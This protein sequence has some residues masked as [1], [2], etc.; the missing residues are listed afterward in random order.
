MTVPKHTEEL[1]ED[2]AASLQVPPGRYE[3]AERSYKSVAEW[4]H[5]AA[6]RVRQANP[7]VYVQGSFRL[8]TAIRPMSDTEDYDVDL[9]C[10]LSLPKAKL[11]QA[12]LKA[13]L[14]D[15]LRSYADAHGMTEPEEGRRCWTQEYADGAQFHMDTLP[16]LPDAAGQRRILAESGFSD[17][18]ADT[19]IA[20]T[21]RDDPNFRQLTEHWPHSNPK[22]YANWFRSR[23]R[24]V[25]D[26]RH[27]ALALEARASVEDIPEH[28]VRTPLQ[29]AIQIL[30]HH[31]DVM[32][33]GR[34][35]DKP[36]SIILTTLAAHAYQQEPIISGALYSILD[37]MDA[38]IDYSTGVA[39]IA[40]PTDP[41]EN[42][43]DRW[44]AYPRREEAFREWLDRVRGDFAAAAQS[45]NRETAN[46]AL[47]PRLGRD[48]IEAAAA[49][50]RDSPLTRIVKSAR[51]VLNPAH[52]KAPPWIRLDQGQVRIE[53]ATM[54]RN[55]F[56]PRGFRSD[57]DP[58]P[59][60]CS[61]VYQADTDIRRPFKVFWQVVN[62]GREAEAANGLRGG[63]DEGTVTAGKLTK[64]ENTLY[65]GRHSIECFI[66][67]AGYLAA[68][69]GQ[70]IVNIQ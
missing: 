19:A 57:G 28:R 17:E 30:K 9:V 40:N 21:D 62:T 43:A 22:G 36:I 8:G 32:F 49:H 1:L 20:I 63:F 56:R 2:L 23:M 35:D 46:A 13:L 3:A 65:T 11:T 24:E 55:G 52:R 18:W 45:L 66:V 64:E 54:Q 48:L 37:R 4:L 41:A 7:S 61:L 5:R 31:R 25:F 33:S 12:Q 50:R 59:K 10:E 70:F 38:H 42:F 14:G 68:R 51:L 53:K 60:R 16:A 58:L 15:E 69:S 6:S 27:R 67:K 44:Q 47:R 39:W 29:S 34:F 26:A